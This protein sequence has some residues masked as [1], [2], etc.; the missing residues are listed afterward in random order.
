M[1][2]VAVLPTGMATPTTVDPLGGGATLKHTPVPI[3][4]AVLG[5]RR[6]PF[7]S[8]PMGVKPT[9]PARLHA[10]PMGLTCR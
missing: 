10:H 6:G 7:N 4:I 9:L 8:T 5:T 2:K 3:N 1:Y